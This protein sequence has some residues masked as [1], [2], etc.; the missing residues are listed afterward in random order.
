MSHLS[1]TAY[2]CPFHSR[3]LNTYRN[4]DGLILVGH[5]VS[6]TMYM[7]CVQS[8]TEICFHLGKIV[9]TCITVQGVHIVSNSVS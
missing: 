2:L 9:P 6:S 7:H 3:L 8:G 4:L 5:A 1:K